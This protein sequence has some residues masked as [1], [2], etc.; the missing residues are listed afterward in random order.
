MEQFGRYTIIRK[1]GEGG[2]ASVY[3][4][5]DAV[6]GDVVLKIMSNQS[7]PNGIDHEK[8]LIDEAR[9]T[10][11]LH[12]KNII[13]IHTA[14]EKST[15]NKSAY[16]VM[17]YLSGGTL[18]DRITRNLPYNPAKVI[19]EIASA[20]D[21]CYKEKEIIHRDLKPTNIL[22]RES[23]TTG[24]LSA[25]L[26]DFGIS[27]SQNN[28]S[29]FTSIGV[30]VGTPKY[31]SPEQFYGEALTQ[32]SDLYSLGIIFYEM[33]VGSVP[34]ESNNTTT[35]IKTITKNERP[36]LPEEHAKY[37]PIINNL[38]SALPEER[39]LNARKLI[40]ALDALEKEKP[41][42]EVASNK[43]LIIG[44]S[45]LT[46]II[47]SG[48]AA[49]KLLPV[50]KTPAD[51]LHETTENSV[52]ETLLTNSTNHQ[53][54]PEETALNLSTDTQTD[55]GSILNED[56]AELNEKLEL[57][58][59][60]DEI[61]LYVSF[62]NTVKDLINKHPNQTE[63][64]EKLTAV[65]E[66]IDLKLS[67]V[68]TELSELKEFNRTDNFNQFETSIKKIINNNSM[69]EAIK[70]EAKT[71]WLDIKNKKNF[72]DKLDTAITLIAKHPSNKKYGIAGPKSLDD[73]SNI[74][75]SINY[76]S[77]L[78]CTYESPDSD[79]VTQMYPIPRTFK[80]KLPYMN[81]TKI[82]YTQ[83]GKL[84][85]GDNTNILVGEAEKGTAKVVCF[86]AEVS[87]Q[88]IITSSFKLSQQDEI[89]YILKTDMLTLE[90]DIENKT[91]NIFGKM[92]F[93]INFK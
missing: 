90:K 58:K 28:Q 89:S 38:L 91:H 53:D 46:L 27:K 72:I 9:R 79:S 17:E 45:L 5:K 85:N 74:N 34:Y 83:Y 31:M 25:V 67:A 73:L 37:Q 93:D 18:K 59:K 68:K 86:S 70:M 14:A 61:N 30:R 78:H 36:K 49:Y 13:R 4:A 50:N 43:A 3:L 35:I 19:R 55:E 12:H 51:T 57:A 76:P 65:E 69:P 7:M 8:L 82:K 42:K 56:I 16:I 87:L 21:Y 23:S 71:I 15:E 88:E 29:D 40:D 77:Y 22:F 1:V 81:H 75:L 6:V 80:D 52:V 33:L 2:T 66:L 39:F 62:K 11:E 44:T 24:E 26:T 63:F 48:Y 41:V 47:I 20:L 32:Q 92:S 60:S 54:P 64:Q 84:L 10:I